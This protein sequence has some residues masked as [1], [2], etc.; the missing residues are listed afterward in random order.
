M[1]SK[2]MEI[3][4]K[5]FLLFVNISIFFSFKI[6]FVFFEDCAVLFDSGFMKLYFNL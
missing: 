1:V 3:H 4:S 5:S 2:N 6:A